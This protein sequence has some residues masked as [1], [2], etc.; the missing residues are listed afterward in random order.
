MDDF[1]EKRNCE[2]WSFASYLAKFGAQTNEDFNEAKQ[3]YVSEMLQMGKSDDYKGYKRLIGKLIND[4]KKLKFKLETPRPMNISIKGDV[5]AS[6]IG[7]P[8]SVLNTENKRKRGSEEQQ[9][10]QKITQRQSVKHIKEDAD[11]FYQVDSEEDIW[12]LWHRFFEECKADEHMH[13][14]SLEKIGIIQ[15]GY[16]VKMRSCLV[17]ELYDHIALK[18]PKYTNIFQN[19]EDDFAHI[20]NSENEMAFITSLKRFKLK[21]HQDKNAL[22]LSK[23]LK[24]LLEIPI[25]A[26]IQL[27]L[28]KS[29]ANYSE[30]FVWQLFKIVSR[31]IDNSIVC[32][33]IGEYKLESIKHEIDRRG[34]EQ[35]KSCSYNA[36][37]CHI[38]V[39]G[40]KTIE[41]SLLEVTGAFGYSDVSR[42]TKDHIKGSFGTLALL[43][44]IGHLFE[45][46]SLDTFQKIRVYFVQAFEEKIWLWSIGQVSQGVCVMELIETA[47]V[48]TNYE[49]S[50]VYIRDVANLLWIYKSCL[51]E[52]LAMIEKLEREHKEV[53]LSI[54]R[55]VINP[56]STTSIVSSLEKGCV[57]KVKGKYISGIKNLK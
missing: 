35:L 51:E 9:Q 32:F 17:E 31:F 4:A 3:I 52:S 13:E 10:E 41:L 55:R 12:D 21:Y 36:D 48:P 49:D 6:I 22:F 19:Y 14:F 8:S 38:G 54:A 15:C 2:N 7:S 26:Q 34:D 39:I 28:K 16:K 29:E 42:R 18:E 44:E 57:L 33:Q 20:F 25:N 47:T 5:V 45:L 37:G 11:I 43:R 40:G 24:L 27:W 46:G 30:Y 1:F 23:I 53:K 50:E 56:T